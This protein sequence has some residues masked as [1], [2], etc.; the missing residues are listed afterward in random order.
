MV[1]RI[2]F[3]GDVKLNSLLNAIREAS[4]WKLLPLLHLLLW[5]SKNPKDR[6]REAVRCGRNADHWDAEGQDAG[7]WAACLISSKQT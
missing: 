6:G 2:I 3:Q 1:S 7:V 4:Q 5:H